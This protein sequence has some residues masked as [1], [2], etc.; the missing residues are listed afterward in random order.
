[1][2][3]EKRAEL[4]KNCSACGELNRHHGDARYLYSRKLGETWRNKLSTFPDCEQD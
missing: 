3:G 1:M 4:L 2:P